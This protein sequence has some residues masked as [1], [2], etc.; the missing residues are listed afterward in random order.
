MPRRKTPQQKKKEAYEHER[1]SMA[2]YPHS[3]RRNKPRDRAQEER[4]FRRK[5]NE[6]VRVAEKTAA[7]E[8]LEQVLGR[9]LRGSNYLLGGP[10]ISLREKVDAKLELRIGR[11][12]WNCFKD[13]YSPRGR[14]TFRKI[15]KA[16]VEGSSEN[17]AALV[18]MF[19]DLIYSEHFGY[20]GFLTQSF[21]DRQNWILRFLADEPELGAEL[22][23]WIRAMLARY[24]E[25]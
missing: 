15:V 12:A 8:D 22:K 14:A 13:P 11:T 5:S 21:S 25:A 16:V 23:S 24:P 2:E 17:S 20:R 19:Q 7:Q 3:A 6:L 9:R 18:R 4:R 1:F 10:C